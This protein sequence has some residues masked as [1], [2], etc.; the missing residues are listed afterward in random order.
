MPTG[1]MAEYNQNADFFKRMK[2]VKAEGFNVVSEQKKIHWTFSLTEYVD[3][4]TH[5][6]KHTCIRMDIHK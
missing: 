4:H 3:K 6:C 2:L 5:I 1:Q